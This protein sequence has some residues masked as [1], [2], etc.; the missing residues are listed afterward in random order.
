MHMR[1]PLF[2]ALSVSLAAVPVLANPVLANSSSLDPDAM[3][4]SLEPD[5]YPGGFTVETATNL[6]AILS[7]VEVSRADTSPLI[8][9][10][11]IYA[12]DFADSVDDLDL[13]AA[14]TGTAVFGYRGVGDTLGSTWHDLVMFR[15]DFPQAASFVSIDLIGNDI[16]DVFGDAGSLV[17]YNGDGDEIGS[18]S[19]D[20]LNLGDIATLEVERAEADIAYVLFT[21]GSNAVG[22]LGGNLDNLQYLVVQTIGGPDPDPDPTP[23]A[24]PTPTAAFAALTMLP[25]LLLRRRSRPSPQRA[26]HEVSGLL[27]KD[28]RTK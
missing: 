25:A 13:L 1:S 17:A 11:G 9:D 14:S 8:D 18:D 4:E 2:C 28:P 23:V 22:N 3:L 19:A 12:I 24:V 16:D 6:S 27:P 10:H 15:A 21:G 26:A 20:G 5:N 7:T